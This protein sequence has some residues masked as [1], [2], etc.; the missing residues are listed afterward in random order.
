[1]NEPAATTQSPALATSEP[2]ERRYARQTRNATVFIAI[3]AGIAAVITLVGVIIAGVE[4]NSLSHALNGVT[5]SS[6]SS[7]CFSQGGTDTSC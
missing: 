3:L 1:L 6:D 2:P 7:N 5:N 4:L